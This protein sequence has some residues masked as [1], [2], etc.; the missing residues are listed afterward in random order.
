MNA[1]RNTKFYMMVGIPGSGK[2]T[3]ISRNLP[4]DIRVVHTDSIRRGV[5]PELP[6]SYHH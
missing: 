5:Y 1:D 3:W 2:T 6:D 4:A